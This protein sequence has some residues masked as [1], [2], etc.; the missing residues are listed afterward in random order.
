MDLNLFC[1]LFWSLYIYIYTWNYPEYFQRSF[2]SSRQ[3][4]RKQFTCLRNLGSTCYINCI[5]QVIRYSPGFLI[6]IQRLI[7]QIVYLKSLVSL[8]NELIESLIY[9]FIY[10]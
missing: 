1:K 2:L 4:N 3:E 6:S 7:K 5:I 9:S 10:C 8:L